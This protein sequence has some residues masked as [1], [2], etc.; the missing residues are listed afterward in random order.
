M[1]RLQIESTPLDGLKIV[2]RQRLGDAR[3][4]LARLYCAD[5][6]AEAGWHHAIAQIN[7]THTARR[8]TVR[9]M[10]FQHPPHAEV[11]L[12]SCLRGEVWDV[13]LDVRAG[14]PTFLQWHAERLS[15]D[16]GRAL[17]IPEGFA[18]GF[19]ALSDDVD[20]LYL[21]THAHAPAAE[22]GLH[23]LDTR[24]SIAWP[25]PITEL[26]ARDAG[27]PAIDDRFKGVAS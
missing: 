17:W 13:A 11:K 24:L 20:M 5:E 16:N 10:H 6:L 22:G 15:G 8:G 4:F 27:H 1:R 19:Q 2:Q 12:V 7:H 26:S 14:S 18:H 21:H 3:G 9:G 23:P 25:L